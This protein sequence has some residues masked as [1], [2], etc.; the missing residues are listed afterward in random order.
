MAEQPAPSP[1]AFSPNPADSIE[2]DEEVKEE[3]TADGASGISRELFREMRAI[4]DTL[5]NHRIAIKGDE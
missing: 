4:C 1:A 2:V 5:S 3:E